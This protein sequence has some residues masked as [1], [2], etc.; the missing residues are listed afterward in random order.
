MTGYQP[1]DTEDRT[2]NNRGSVNHSIGPAPDEIKGVITLTKEDTAFMVRL[3]GAALDADGWDK[4]VGDS[5]TIL[6]MDDVWAKAIERLK[7][8]FAERDD[9][10]RAHYDTVNEYVTEAILYG[11][12]LA[13]VIQAASGDPQSVTRAILDKIEGR[14]QR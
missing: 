9:L 11:L 1:E 4:R 5:P 10:D 6:K 14:D 7:L 8:P 2:T 12:H 13:H 3:I